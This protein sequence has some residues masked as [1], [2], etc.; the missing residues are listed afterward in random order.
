MGEKRG[1]GRCIATNFGGGN[2]RSSVKGLWKSVVVLILTLSCVVGA[3]R[4]YA[5]NGEKNIIVCVGALVEAPR[6][7]TQRHMHMCIRPRGCIYGRHVQY[8]RLYCILRLECAVPV[9]SVPRKRPMASGLAHE[10][11]LLAR[12]LKV[13]ALHIA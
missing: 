2:E 8:D 9:V 11:R 7:H 3:N 1:L 6:S 10:L 13:H 12:G 5:Q 4:E